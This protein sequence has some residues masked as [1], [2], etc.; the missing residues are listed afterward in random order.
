MNNEAFEELKVIVQDFNKAFDA[1]TEKWGCRVTF[2]WLY[3]NGSERQ[4]KAMEILGIDRI[5]WRK[6]PPKSLS[7]IM[8]QADT[9]E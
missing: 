3:G 6:P 4:I 2:G 5:V 8:D 9:G 7:Q 1:W